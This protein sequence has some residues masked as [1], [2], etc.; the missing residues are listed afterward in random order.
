M[1]HNDL[2][3]LDMNANSDENLSELL[4]KCNAKSLHPILLENRITYNRLKYFNDKDYEN[5]NIPLGIKRQIENE[6]N[7]IS[8]INSVKDN[9]NNDEYMSIERLINENYNSDSINNGMSILVR[10]NRELTYD[11]LFEIIDEGR[12]NMV[13]DIK[14]KEILNEQLIKE[15]EELRKEKTRKIKESKSENTCCV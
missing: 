1:Y 12:K 10:E 9:Y 11:N 7:F 5:Y 6:L 3:R 13:E 4:D 8:V 15:Y 14:N 2:Y